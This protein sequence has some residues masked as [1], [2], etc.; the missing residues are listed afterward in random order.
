MVE[1][2]FPLEEYEARWERAYDA[3]RARG[4]AAAVVWSRSGGTYDRAADVLYLVNR[5]SSSSGQETD[6]RLNTARSYSA[7]ILVPGEE[8]ELHMDDP[9]DRRNLIATDHVRGHHDPIRGVADALKVRGITGEVALVGSDFFPIKYF[10]ALE[11]ATPG[12]EWRFCDDLVRGLRR[13]KS[14]RE[15]NCLREGGVIASRA[16]ECLMEGLVGGKT[17]AEAVADAVHTLIAAGATCQMI[18]VSH[19]A[20]IG[21]WCR[22]PLIGY[23]TERPKPGDLVRGWLDSAIFQGYWLDPGAT[24]VAGSKPT[25]DQS[26][27]LKNCLSIVDGVIEAIRP[28]MTAMELARQGDRL[29]Q[30]AGSGNS[31]MNE[32]WPLYGHGIG[33]YWEHPYIGV[34]MCEPDATIDPGMAL[35]IEAFL[36]VEGVGTAA[37][38]RNLIVTD[39]GAELITHT[40]MLGW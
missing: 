30:A 33:L 29:A 10:Q 3:M 39:D 18:P 9:D 15:Q 19:G 16:M 22:D 5:A 24:A 26:A 32:Q 27:L 4:L 34:S 11:A 28:G 20:E 36:A 38:K 7:V 1:R 23:T 25:A 13:I 12:I 6:N 35:G 31:Q 14:P 2:Y 40:R 37:F 8:P 21:Y 17:E